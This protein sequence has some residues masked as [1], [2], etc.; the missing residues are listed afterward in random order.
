MSYKEQ[1]TN[2]SSHRADRYPG[3]YARHL[4]AVKLGLVWACRSASHTAQDSPPGIRR[5][6][7]STDMAE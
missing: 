7:T 4:L 5:G 6:K 3:T 1:E 2:L